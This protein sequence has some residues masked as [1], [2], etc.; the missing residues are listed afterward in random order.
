MRVTPNRSLNVATS[1]RA[2]APAELAPSLGLDA[3]AVAGAYRALADAHVIV[4]RPGTV[5]IA[6]AP[7]FFFSHSIFWIAGR[8]TLIVVVRV[9]S[10]T[11][12]SSPSAGAAGMVA[13]ADTITTAAGRPLHGS[14]LDPSTEK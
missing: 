3:P 7:P 14:K 5:E 2:P 8:F 6:W 9:D 12:G 11:A 1:I 4:L 13:V 10:S